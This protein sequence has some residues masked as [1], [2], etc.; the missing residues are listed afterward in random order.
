MEYRP[1]GKGDV[2]VACLL[3]A[4]VKGRGQFWEGTSRLGAPAPDPQL[5][6]LA[7]NLDSARR[8]PRE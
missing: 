8:P 1:K 2:L 4:R 5:G 3:L 7:H 6:F